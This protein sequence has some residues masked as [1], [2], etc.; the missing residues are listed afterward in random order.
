MK[1]RNLIYQIGLSFIFIGSICSL[2]AY[3][4]IGNLNKTSPSLTKPALQQQYERLAAKFKDRSV[5]KVIVKLKSTKQFS[6]EKTFIEEYLHEIKDI[7]QNFLVKLTAGKTHLVHQFKY[8]P[9]VAL[10]V[11]EDGLKYLTSFS[12]VE[13]ISE[14]SLKKPL[15]DESTL[16]V[17][18]DDA[19]AAG[20]SGS[21]QYV[22]IV[23]TGV[24][25][26][27]SMLS[28]K[29]T[30]EGC[31]S[32]NAP[33][34]YAS[35]LCPSGASE[36]YGQGAARPC[37][38]IEGCDHGT[39]VAGIAAGNDSNYSGVAK[40]ANI[41]AYQVFTKFNDLLTCFY[42]GSY[43]YPCLAA[44]DSDILAALEDVLDAKVISN[45]PIAAVN[46]SLGWGQYTSACDSD[47]DVSAF[48]QMINSLRS[49][50]VATAVASG[51]DGFTNALAGPACVSSAISVGNTTDSDTVNSSS[52]SAS[53]LDILAPGTNITSSVPGGYATYTGTS[54]AAPHVTGA[55]A[56]LRSQNPNLTVDQIESTLKTTGKSIT[57]T[58][59]GLTFPRLDLGPYF[60]SCQPG[61]KKVSS[62]V[63]SCAP[64]ASGDWTLTE[65][66][67]DDI[68][69]S[70]RSNVIVQNNALLTIQNGVSLGINFLTNSLKVKNG[71][72]ILIKNGGKIFHD[73]QVP[74][75]LLL[76]FDG[77]DG[78]KTIVDEAGHSVTA[79]GDAQLDTAEKQSGTAS[80]FLDGS[81]DYLSI[82]DSDDWYFGTGNFTLDFWVKFNVLTTYASIYYQRQDTN[83]YIWLYKNTIHGINF[84]SRA[85]GVDI[86][87]FYTG[88]NTVTAGQWYHIQVVRN[89]AE[90]SI[91][92]NDQSKPLTYSKD[93]DAS[94][95]YPNLTA[96]VYIGQENSAN[97][98][99]GWLDEF[100]LT[101]F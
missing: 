75:K 55:I 46:L 100:K 1:Y 43:S 94:T 28:G 99:N 73:A 21:G 3:A 45:Q 30:S 67:L 74:P 19:W 84:E 64:P 62:A 41:Y 42:L 11:D 56:V 91:L 4:Q 27:H 38:G 8:I 16:I 31:H 88:A 69:V 33:E 66:C 101:R 80:L 95:S 49:A 51:N 93:P 20:Y 35:S 77:T 22:A 9:F 6:P 71:S 83:N 26:T 76:H 12:E 96:P 34:Y 23:D 13:N 17:N 72:G 98:L 24:D 60:A 37:S 70:P 58:R 63:C 44:F 86:S 54:M 50:E 25:R 59:N 92:I 2:S 52:D 39:H 68:S 14:D 61:Q 89:G 18:A 97:F 82:A 78:S 36:E 85:G 81:G 15:L 79:V 87:N 47:P 57:D 29:V 10:E 48:T 65:N 7:Q 53:F 32:T 5:L 40:N 90:E